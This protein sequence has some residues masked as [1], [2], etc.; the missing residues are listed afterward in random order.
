MIIVGALML[1][2]LIAPNGIFNTMHG[3]VLFT[4]V[5]QVPVS[6]APEAG[7][8]VAMD[9]PLCR[10]RVTWCNSSISPSRSSAGITMS[11]AAG[12]LPPSEFP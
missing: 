9:A 12:T 8:M 3:T 6:S 11:P 4:R 5:G 2:G 7:D 1:G 10:R